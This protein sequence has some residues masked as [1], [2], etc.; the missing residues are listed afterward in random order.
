MKNGN[1]EVKRRKALQRQR[2]EARREAE[3]LQSIDPLWQCL[4]MHGD[5]IGKPGKGMAS[6]RSGTRR[7][8][9]DTRRHWIDQRRSDVHGGGNDMLSFDAKGI[10]GGPE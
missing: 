1:E 8:R 6:G 2:A 10:G 7:Q 9:I 5:G 4:G 3:E